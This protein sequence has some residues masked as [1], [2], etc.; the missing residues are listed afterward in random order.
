MTKLKQYLTILSL[1]FNLSICTLNFQNELAFK[2]KTVPAFCQSHNRYTNTQMLIPYNTQ[3]VVHYLV[4]AQ[5]NQGKQVKY[6]THR[7]PIL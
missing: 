5:G 7:N 6:T 1:I 2:C 3:I 4:L